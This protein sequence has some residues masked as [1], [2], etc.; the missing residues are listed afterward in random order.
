MRRCRGSRERLIAALAFD[1]PNSL[2]LASMLSGEAD[3]N[4]TYL[5]IHAGAGGTESQD[6]AEMLER[7]YIAL[8]GAQGLQAPAHRRERGRRRRNQ[9][10]D[11][12]GQGRERLWL[13]EDGSGRP[14]ARADFSRSTPMRGDTRASPASPFF[15]S[16]IRRSKS[17]S[18]KRTCASIRIVRPARAAST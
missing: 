5:E 6:W 12:A 16:S 15:P 2:R 13:A 3:G 7:M 8:G 9:I 1:A 10:R 17:T 14:P 18:R 4:D 11:A